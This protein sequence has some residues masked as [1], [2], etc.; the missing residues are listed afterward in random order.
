MGQR[1]RWI[2][3]SMF[4]F[5]KVQKEME[6]FKS[7][8]MAVIDMFL[9]LQI[10]YLNL[11]NTLVYF[12]PAILLFTFHLTM[13]TIR[14]DYLG[15]IFAISNPTGI[16]SVIYA[17]FVNVMDFLYA[18]MFF[19]I[20]FLSI[21]LTHSNKKFIYYIYF[22]STV[23]GLFSVIT[24]VVILV[25]IIKGFAGGNNCSYTYI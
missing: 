1:K 12:A 5:E 8:K 22:F 19:G 13:Q 25:D 24:F 2:N 16:G 23:F 20:I 17:T 18:L 4:A 11:S 6:N 9:K 21:H 15:S 7:E 3:G 14:A 10:F